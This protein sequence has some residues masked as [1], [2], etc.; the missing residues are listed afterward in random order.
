MRRY[1]EAERDFDQTISL[2]PQIPWG[3]IVK[4][5]VLLARD[6][7]VGAAKRVMSEMSRRVNM[8]D[9]AESHVTQVPDY[10][11]VLRTCP[12]TFTEA[13]DAFESGPMERFRRIQPAAIATTHLSRAEVYE[14]KGDRRSAIARYDS[15]RV[16]Y[17]RIIRSNPESAYICFYHMALGLAY[18]G[19]GRKEE[20]I[21]EGEDAVRMMPISKD[22]LVGAELV[23]FLPEIY[24]MCGEYE[25]AIDRIETAL[26]VPSVVSAGALRVDPKWDPLRSNP[27]FRRLVEGK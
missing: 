15:A 11:A 25:A 8:A 22:A 12:E 10:F 26:S 7:N 18:A 5:H 24:V 1:D 21:R 17:E 23:G 3:Y 20:A 2:A 16:Y 19:I 13:F 4:A 6:G 27:R 9:V 14:A